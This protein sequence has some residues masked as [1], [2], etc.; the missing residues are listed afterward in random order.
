MNALRNV[1]A[2]AMGFSREMVGNGPT[3]DSRIGLKRRNQ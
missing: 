2:T 3:F 1:L